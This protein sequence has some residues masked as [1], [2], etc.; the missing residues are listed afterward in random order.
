MGLFA[1]LCGSSRSTAVYE[2]T[3]LY[4]P[5]SPHHRIASPA[6]TAKMATNT[7]TNTRSTCSAHTTNGGQCNSQARSQSLTSQGSARSTDSS[8]SDLSSDGSIDSY[9]GRNEIAMLLHQ[10]KQ[11]RKAYDAGGLTRSL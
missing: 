1:R 8:G 3:P 6:S 2:P 9:G 11:L 7:N 10:Y 4:E 5:T